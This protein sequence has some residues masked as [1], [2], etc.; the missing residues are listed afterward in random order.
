GGVIGSLLDI[1]GMLT[2]VFLKALDQSPRL[3]DMDIDYL[4]SG[5]AQPTLGRAE[6]VRG[7]RR[8]A[9]LRAVLWQDDP[10]RPIAIG[11]LQFLLSKTETTRGGLEVSR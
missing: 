11:R 7:G 3:I 6:I 2:L 4:R 5:Q 10:E 9:N 8:M 1:T